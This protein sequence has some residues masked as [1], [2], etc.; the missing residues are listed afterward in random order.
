MILKT[1]EELASE[2]VGGPLVRG[3]PLI[4]AVFRAV[5]AWQK[6][7]LMAITRRDFLNGVAVTIA[8]GLTLWIWSER[9]EKNMNLSMEVI[10]LPA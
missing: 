10:T 7:K 3:D 9:Q 4:C 1:D 6:D 5:C 2:V 8:A